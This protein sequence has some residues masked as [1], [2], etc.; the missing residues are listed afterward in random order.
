MSSSAER[1]TSPLQPLPSDS[2]DLDVLFD[3]PDSAEQLPSV[4]WK[5]PD[6]KIVDLFVRVENHAVDCVDGGP[7]MSP[8]RLT[9]PER[10]LLTTLGSFGGELEK[11]FDLLDGQASSY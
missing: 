1:T 5:N 9:Q 10:D 6:M 7:A 4:I 11:R 8:F 2:R 3:S